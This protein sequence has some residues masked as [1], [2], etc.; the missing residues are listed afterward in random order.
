MFGLNLTLISLFHIR[1][2]NLLTLYTIHYTLH[3]THQYFKNYSVILKYDRNKII[4]ANMIK[5]GWMAKLLS[6]IG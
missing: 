4:C 6:K 3:T 5:I 2:L 1:V